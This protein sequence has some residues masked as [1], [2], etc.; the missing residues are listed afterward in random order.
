MRVGE[1]DLL[2]TLDIVCGGTALEVDG[3]V[4]HE[5]DTVGRGYQCVLDVNLG[6]LE[7]RLD[8]LDDL[9]ADIQSVADRLLLVVIVGERDRG[10]AVAN[11]D[12]ASILDLFQRAAQLLCSERR[13]RKCD[14]GERQAQWFQVVPH[15]F[16]LL[17]HRM[18]AW[19][20][21]QGTRSGKG[22]QRRSGAG[23]TRNDPLYHVVLGQG[24]SRT[25]R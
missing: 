7:L 2:L 22:T 23:V 19:S 16:L 18:I 10:I 8:R 5:G 3:A 17:A 24:R 25:T 11:R 12:A 9:A 21:T 6:E 1:A 13:R 20:M 4:R 15:C 14:R